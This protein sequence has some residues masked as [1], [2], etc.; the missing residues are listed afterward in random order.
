MDALPMARFNEGGER[1]PEDDRDEIYVPKT[2]QEQKSSEGQLEEQLR[3]VKIGK[4]PTQPLAGVKLLLEEF[5]GVFR[6]PRPGT[7]PRTIVEHAIPFRA[8]KFVSARAYRLG[9]TQTTALED[10]VKE[11]LAARMIRPSFPPFLSDF[12][13]PKKDASG[14]VTETRWV[15]DYRA[16]NTNT[17]PDHYPLPLIEELLSK[18][19]KAR[20]FSKVDLKSSHWQVLLRR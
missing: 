15:V 6:N 5:K 14:K 13:I 16:I 18:V 8:D 4:L 9:P 12:P 3:A 17:I 1:D 10:H 2:F 19:T 7:V 20:I 11:L